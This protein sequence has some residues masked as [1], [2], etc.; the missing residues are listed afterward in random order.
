MDR[1]PLC[2]RPGCQGTTAAWLTYDYSAQ[3]V[4]LDDV[5]VEDGGDQW[6]LCAGHAGR[7]RAPQGWT[8][9]DR[10]VTRPSRYEPPTSLVS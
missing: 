5:P 8:Q 1:R 3:R 4:W 2:A 7:L 10:R 6:A 9:V